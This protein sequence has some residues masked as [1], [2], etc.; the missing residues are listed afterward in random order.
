[1]R[2]SPDA[3]PL[4]PT[5]IIIGAEHQEKAHDGGEDDDV[6]RQNERTG[7]PGDLKTFNIQ[8]KSH[9]NHRTPLTGHTA[10][11]NNTF[12]LY[13]QKQKYILVV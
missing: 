10:I 13:L 8:N 4:L 2:K 1:M 11:I 3:S 12:S 6:S 9:R 7:S 5:E